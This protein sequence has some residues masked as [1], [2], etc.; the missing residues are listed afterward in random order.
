MRRLVNFVRR[1]CAISFKP[2][3]SRYNSKLEELKQG[4]RRILRRNLTAREEQLLE[5]SESML[6][7]DLD[8]SP[9]PQQKHSDTE[10][11]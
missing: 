10:A 1:S 2:V 9:R 8:D 7:T 5:L 6:A 3:R 11:A 4:F